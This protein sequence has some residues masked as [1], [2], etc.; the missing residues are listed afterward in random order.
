[1]ISFGGQF[2]LY[3]YS[4]CLSLLVVVVM[5]SRN[6]VAYISIKSSH[7]FPLTLLHTY[8]KDKKEKNKRLFLC[9]EVLSNRSIIIILTLTLV[10]FITQML[11]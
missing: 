7:W 1:M 10:L 6:T 4:E 5:S 8:T 11:N 3:F 2:N 9:W